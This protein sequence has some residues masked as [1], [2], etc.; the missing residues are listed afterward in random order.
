MSEIVPFDEM[1]ARQVADLHLNNLG[2]NFSGQTGL[3]FLTAYYRALISSGGG[4]GFLALEQGKLI[5]F[6]CGVWAP[7]KIRRELLIRFG[8]VLAASALKMAFQ[9]PREGMRLVQRFLHGSGG[10]KL[11]SNGY[12]LRPIAVVKEARGTNAA[13]LLL[14]ALL[15]DANNRKY[16]CVF[17]YTEIENVRAQKFYEKNHFVKV[18]TYPNNNMEYIRYE[19][20]GI[21]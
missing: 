3:T 18:S 12:E 15:M 7:W 14:D 5:G 11:P 16:D 9:A 4:C 21:A 19:R 10:Q 8:V 17:L 20:K 13:S 2:T 6:V 1:Y